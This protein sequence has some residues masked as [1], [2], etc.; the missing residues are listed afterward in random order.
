MREY[1]VLNLGAGVQSTC[2]Y[3]L[4]REKTLACGCPVPFRFDYA[5]FADT[6]EEPKAIYDHLAWL[7]TINDPPILVRTAGSLGDNLLKNENLQGHRFASIP[8]FT[9]PDHLERPEGWKAGILRRQ[10]TAEYKINVIVQ[11]IRK[12]LLGLQPRKHVPKDVKVFQYFGI[13]TDEIDRT[14]TKLQRQ[15]WAIPVY[16]FI[17][18][19]WSR[20][21]CIKW[22]KGRVPHEVPRSACVFCPYH[23]NAEWQRIKDTDPEA[24]ARAIEVDE[25]LRKE[26]AVCNRGM[27]QKMYLHRQ[28]VPLQMVDFSAGKDAAQVGG[29]RNECQGMCG[30]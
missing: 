5:I 14:K 23:S 7:Q 29:M 8:A 26:G 24:W 21:D 15:P 22:L 30:V 12:E 4:S 13:T 11:T 25:G 1:H 2:L 9:A 27:E 28:C 10:C 16:P 17:E 3:L 6:Q 18:M 19:G 20:Q